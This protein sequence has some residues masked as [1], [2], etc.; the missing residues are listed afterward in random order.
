M[1]QRR[2]DASLAKLIA[3]C[4]V[5]IRVFRVIRVLL[6]PAED[7]LRTRISRMTRMRRQTSSLV[8]GQFQTVSQASESLE[9]WSPFR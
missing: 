7:I 4:Q 5:S 9:E 3:E 2:S 8:I 1:P 6:H